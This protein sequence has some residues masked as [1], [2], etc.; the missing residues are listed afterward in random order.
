MRTD[1]F[2]II[3]YV[4]VLLWLAVPVLWLLH[5]GLRPRKWLCHVALAAAIA[6]FVLAKINSVTYVNRIQLDTSKQMAEWQAKQ[7]A[8]LKEAEAQRSEDVADIRFAEDAAGDYLDRAGMDEADLKYMDKL[9]EDVPAWKK[10]KKQR[11]NNAAEDNSLEA[12]IGAK[13][14]T[15]GMESDATESAVEKDPVIML[16]KDK[17]LANRLD[18]MNLKIIRVLILLGVVY[19]VYDYMHRANS[20]AEAY[21]PLPLPSRWLDNVSPA[22]PLL[23]LPGKPR[24][25]AVD[26][27]KWITRKGDVFVY[28]TDKSGAAEQVPASIPGLMGKFKPIDVMR[29][30]SSI[31]D[32]FVFES[33]WYRRSSFVVD[34]SERAIQMLGQFVA[35][36]TERRA[37][38]ARVSQ[39]VHIVWDMTAPLADEWLADFAKLMKTTGMS[40][41]ICPA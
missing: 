6:A 23:N 8:K 31:E 33:L 30:D 27:L 20:Y 26:E 25:S 11:S 22:P 5:A 14:E 17:M 9:N 16:E 38:R 32:R 29:V 34:S 18:G 21:M 7:D 15:E 36:L 39:T 10:E 19:L 37:S 24:R 41:V 12:Q 2:S 35:Y 13:T 4:S 40:L 1:Y 3:G 28:M